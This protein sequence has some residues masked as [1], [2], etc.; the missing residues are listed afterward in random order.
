MKCLQPHKRNKKLVK[1]PLSGVLNVR[2]R[3]MVSAIVMMTTGI[4]SRDFQTICRG[5]FTPK[6]SQGSKIGNLVVCGQ[7]FKSKTNIKL[8]TVMQMYDT[9]D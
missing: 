2:R 8:K 4:D 3:M 7:N 6:F 1:K 9:N 5:L